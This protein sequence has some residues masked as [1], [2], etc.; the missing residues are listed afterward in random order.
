MDGPPLGPGPPGALDQSSRILAAAN[1][2]TESQL[3]AGS[4]PEAGSGHQRPSEEP[5]R[6]AKLR[7]TDRI[8]V[9]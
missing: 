6:S 8:V 2:F 3:A 1:E 7:L 5:V 9:R 4:M